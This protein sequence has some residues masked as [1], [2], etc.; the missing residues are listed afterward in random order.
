M[1]AMKKIYFPLEEN[2]DILKKIYNENFIKASLNDRLCVD[3]CIE[4]NEHLAEYVY[5]K[6]IASLLSSGDIK[7]L[8]SMHEELKRVNE[9]KKDY[10]YDID[11]K[12]V[13]L[14]LIRPENIG[15]VDKYERFLNSLTIDVIYKK[16][17]KINFEQYWMLYHHGLI[18]EDA[19]CDFPTRT[20][21]YVNKLCCLL[22]VK[23]NNY[24][25]QSLPDF[26]NTI[27]GK[28]GKFK[29]GTLRGEVGYNSLKNI[30]TND[31]LYFNEK[32]N[33]LL[34]DPTGMCR[35]LSRGQIQSDNSHEIADL[36]LLFY[37]GQAVHI[38]DYSEILDDISTLCDE[39]DAEKIKLKI[40]K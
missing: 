33:N 13:G 37:V 30:V 8:N 38:P 2:L 36:K 29:S 24:I 16:Y 5:G 20:L 28:Q 18:C 35:L 26:L 4:A 15:S 27:K 12:N 14:L 3:D 10:F 40:K 23:T 21:N 25:G 1:K 9:Y 11:F 34:F 39:S 32:M 6:E 31:G 22:V 19:V 7:T 17:I